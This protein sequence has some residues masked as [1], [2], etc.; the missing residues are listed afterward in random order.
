LTWNLFKGSP[1][2]SENLTISNACLVDDLAKN[3]EDVLRHHIGSDADQRM[4]GEA[5][6][7]AVNRRPREDRPVNPLAEHLSDRGCVRFGGS[8]LGADQQKTW[9]T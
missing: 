8:K 1:D 9:L 7:P 4:C 3:L 6:D 2:F 5:R